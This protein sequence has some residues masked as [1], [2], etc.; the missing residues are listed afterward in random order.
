MRVSIY[1]VCVCVYNTDERAVCTA[2]LMMRVYI[3]LSLIAHVSL[4]I[5]LHSCI[6]YKNIRMQGLPVS[7]GSKTFARHTHTRLEYVFTTLYILKK[8]GE[9]S[10]RSYNTVKTQSVYTPLPA[11]EHDATSTA[12]YIML[13]LR[14]RYNIT[15]GIVG[16]FDLHIS[17]R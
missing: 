1:C 13:L 11:T 14:A 3:Y 9:S 10:R 17:P 12:T 8:L 7:A 15:E 16:K 2:F 6:E 5:I 4:I